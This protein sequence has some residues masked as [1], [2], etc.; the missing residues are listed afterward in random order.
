V[1]SSL[2]PINDV[3]IHLVEASLTVTLFT[4]FDFGIIISDV[5]FRLVVSLGSA[6]RLHVLLDE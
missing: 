1:I 3:Y 5:A 6:I 4:L 2:S